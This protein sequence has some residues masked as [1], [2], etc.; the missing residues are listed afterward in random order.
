MSSRNVRS[1]VF[2]L[3]TWLG[4]HI[5]VFMAFL[6]LTGTL[7]V[8]MPELEVAGHP[9]AFSLLPTEQRTATMGQIYDSVTATYPD[10]GVVVIERRYGTISADRTQLYAPWG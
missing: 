4:L 2:R 7:L 3:H 1:L 6:F 8:V 9:G 5:S 10:T